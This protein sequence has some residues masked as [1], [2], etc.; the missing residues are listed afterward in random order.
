MLI[1]N[2]ITNYLLVC[3]IA[4]LYKIF[5]QMVLYIIIRMLQNV[6]EMV[7]LEKLII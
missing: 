1:N 3:I 6:L 7:F 2:L 5:F 4:H